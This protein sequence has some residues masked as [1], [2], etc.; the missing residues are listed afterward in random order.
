MSLAAFSARQLVMLDE[1]GEETPTSSPLYSFSAPT[2]KSWPTARSDGAAAMLAACIRQC[3]SS[4]TLR[5]WL[6]TAMVAIAKL[7]RYL[8]SKMARAMT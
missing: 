8:S 4:A 3:A 6:A 5:V 7:T 1:P 2:L